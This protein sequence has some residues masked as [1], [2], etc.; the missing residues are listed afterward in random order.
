MKLS[1]FV[2]T[3]YSGKINYA[4]ILNSIQAADI[5]GVEVIISDNSNDNEKFKFLKKFQSANVRIFKGP[6]KNNHT[7]ALA[8]TRAKHVLCVGDDDMLLPS[9]L[10]SL[11]K[12]LDVFPDAVGAM[13]IYGRNMGESY[14]FTPLSNI[15]QESCEKRITGLI[16]TVG[17]GNPLFHAVIR[18]DIL[19][20]IY[21]FYWNLPNFQSFHDHI[22]T[23]FLT[24]LGP[25]HL[26]NQP[27]FIYNFVNWKDL[28]TRISSE[29]NI[30]RALNQPPSFVLLQRLILATEGYYLIQSIFPHMEDS[31]ERQ[32]AS[33]AWFHRWF[34]LWQGS[35]NEGY[36]NNEKVTNCKFFNHAYKLVIK[37]QFESDLNTHEILNDIS[38]FYNAVNGSGDQYQ[39]FWLSVGQ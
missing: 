25:I 32:R 38:E 10:H 27:Y 20:E 17:I 9:G 35:L 12:K 7:F 39:K 13:G 3:H 2:P 36:K 23:L 28:S 6:K 1:L 4:S 34:Q 19:L 18:R 16:D 29:I 24:C 33:F 30:L 15:D 8:Q 31:N 11:I 37:Y 5:D 14:D 22:A 21:D 26:T